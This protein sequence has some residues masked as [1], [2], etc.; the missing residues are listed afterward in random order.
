M[1]AEISPPLLNKLIEVCVVKINSAVFVIVPL[2]LNIDHIPA[3]PETAA[4]T[5]VK[6]DVKKT[7][8]TRLILFLKFII[9]IYLLNL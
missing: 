9:I 6:I 4:I 1:A 2:V 8:I 7:L 3:T 5:N